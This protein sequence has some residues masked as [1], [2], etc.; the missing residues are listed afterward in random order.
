MA[1]DKI[2][3]LV[4]KHPILLTVIAVIVMYILLTLL[5]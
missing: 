3:R 1:A 2:K 5:K 4:E